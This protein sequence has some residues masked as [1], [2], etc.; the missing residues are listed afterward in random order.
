[1][2]RLA[3][4]LSLLLASTAHAASRDYPAGTFT[5]PKNGHVLGPRE[6]VRGVA[7]ATTVNVPKTHLGPVVTSKD[8]AKLKA[9]NGG[10]WDYEGAN[11]RNYVGHVTFAFQDG[12]PEYPHQWE[13]H[14]WKLPDAKD[15][16]AVQLWA[17]APTLEYVHVSNYAGTAYKIGC[18]TGPLLGRLTE[19]DREQARLSH[20]SSGRCF[21][22]LE[23]ENG[24]DGVFEDL[25]FYSGRDVGIN[26]KGAAN[27]FTTVHVAGFLGKPTADD[28]DRGIG[29]LNGP[30]ANIYE[31]CQPDYCSRGMVNHGPGTIVRDF[32]AKLC[33]DV[34]IDAHKPMTI[35]GL[36]IEN[37]GGRNDGKS[38]F[39]DAPLGVHI[40]PTAGRTIVNGGKWSCGQATHFVGSLI[41]AS[42][43]IVRNDETSWGGKVST[44]VCQSIGVE[45]TLVTGNVVVANASG[46]GVGIDVLFPLGERNKLIVDHDGS[47][48]LPIRVKDGV[49]LAGVT[50]LV[51][52]EKWEESK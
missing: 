18:G 28:P 14:A 33:V 1:V 10:R 20:V 11:V 27:R 39:N 45:G 6:Y 26:C 21:S 8:Y 42:N 12:V 2:T 5:A 35:D 16:A 51:N 13:A 24:A 46:Y 38:P 36:E 40:R 43:N 9:A 15:D 41:E 30:H 34:C 22:G 31:A 29:F 32:I 47:C 23:I 3:L 17:P 7:H 50:V 49:S 37:P 4:I 25:D 52:G 19:D 44:T 48:P